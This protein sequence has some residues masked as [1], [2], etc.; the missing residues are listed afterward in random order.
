[1]QIAVLSG[2]GGTGKTTIA[3]G[4]AEIIKESIK[5]DCDVD[6]ANMYLFYNGTKINFD[7]FYS[8]KKAH[9]N[10]DKCKKCGKCI[11]NCKF[12]AIDNYIVDSLK[13]E[14][15][16]VCKLVCPSDAIELY[17]NKV[18]DIIEDKLKDKSYL[19]RSEMEIG[20]DGSGRLITE[21]RK[22]TDKYINIKIIDGSPGIGCSVIASITGVDICILVT[23]PTISGLNDLKRIYELTKN[24]ESKVLVCINKYDINIEMTEKI[25]CYCIDNNIEIIGLISYDDMVLKSVNDLKP[26]VLYKES[27][28]GKEITNI[29]NKII[30]KLE[31]IGN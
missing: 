19:I 15:C 25:K 14:G 28:A 21:L 22:K 8:G 17:T 10:E 26:I 23:E 27:I 7:K 13:C 12:G 20:A 11:S 16:S 18:A 30:K 9:I 6:A 31:R 4:I 5:V 24:F 3:V 2:K 1:M 29:A